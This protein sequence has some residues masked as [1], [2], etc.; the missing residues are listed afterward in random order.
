MGFSVK[1]YLPIIFSVYCFEKSTVKCLEV[2][3]ENFSIVNSYLF[4][5]NRIKITYELRENFRI[6][7]WKS[8]INFGHFQ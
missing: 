1:C 5:K 8:S 2:F 7:S 6:S 3:R 4:F